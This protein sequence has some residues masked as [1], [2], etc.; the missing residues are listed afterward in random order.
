VAVGDFHF[1]SL[2]RGLSSITLKPRHTSNPLSSHLIGALCTHHSQCTEL[3]FCT[4]VVFAPHPKGTRSPPPYGSC[5]PFGYF[6]VFKAKLETISK[7]LAHWL[8]SEWVPQRQCSPAPPPSHS[9]NCSIRMETKPIV[10]RES[11]QVW[12]RDYYPNYNA[13]GYLPSKSMPQLRKAPR[14][15]RRAW[16]FGFAK[17][18]RSREATISRRRN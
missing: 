5:T 3:F 15:T 1:S 2:A 13:Q 9:A 7:G 8:P 17:V 6:F 12:S 14:R 18:A 4:A 10:L 16:S 11:L